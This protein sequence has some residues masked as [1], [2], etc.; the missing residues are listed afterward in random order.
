MLFGGIVAIVLGL[1]CGAA[2][3]TG[4]WSMWVRVGLILGYFNACFLGLCL[5]AARGAE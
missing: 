1:T 3:L 4:E 5:L 2:A